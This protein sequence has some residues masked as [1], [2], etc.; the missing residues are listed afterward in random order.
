MNGLGAYKENTV[1]TQSPGGIV[2]KLYDGAIRFLKQAILRQQENDFAERG[3]LINSAVAII[4]ELNFSLNMEVG[5]EVTQNLRQ[6]YQFM[7]R[8]LNQAHVQKDIQKIR[9]VV[10]LLEE[11]N[12]AWKQI[13]E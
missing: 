11:L 2:V 4:E 9:D 1:V 7:I 5:G 13:V 12:S 8:H 6:L 10:Q 3:R